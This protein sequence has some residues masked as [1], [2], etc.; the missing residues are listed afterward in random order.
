MATGTKKSQMESRSEYK[1]TYSNADQQKKSQFMRGD[2][3]RT[4]KCFS[5]QEMGHNILNCPK[6]ILPVSL[7]LRGDRFMLNATVEGIRC[8][9]YVWTHN[10]LR[11]IANQLT[12]ST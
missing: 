1:Q 4:E 12:L 10:V 6:K 3:F 5:C 7:P 11:T 8:Y 2:Y 9:S